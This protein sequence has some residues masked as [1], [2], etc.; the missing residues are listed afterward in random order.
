MRIT[1]IFKKLE[2]HMDCPVIFSDQAGPKPS[3]PY[4]TI[5]ETV[6]YIPA[7]G[8]STVQEEHLTEDIKVTASSQP[9]VS[10]SITAYSNT[11][12]ESI[13]VA[14]KAY[15][16]FDFV[17]YYQLK[18]DGY[19]VVEV[20]SIMNRDSLIVDDYE[21]KRGFDVELRFVHEQTRIDEEIKV[22]KG[23]INN[24]PFTSKRSD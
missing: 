6:S 9:T 14:Q 7:R 24:R 1:D 10:L 12:P 2:E 22:V 20:Q 4:I 19:V 3:Y 17:G 13:E 5:N 16:W 11:I 15:D 23:T 8:Q 21:R 18:R